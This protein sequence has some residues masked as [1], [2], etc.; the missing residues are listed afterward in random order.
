MPTNRPKDA[1]PCRRRPTPE[2]IGNRHASTATKIRTVAIS[3]APSIAPAIEPPS[4]CP[5]ARPASPASVVADVTEPVAYTDRMD[6]RVE[7][8]LREAVEAA[9]AK[10]GVKPAHYIRNALWTALQPRDAGSLYDVNSDGKRRWA[11]IKKDGEIC[12]M[13]YSAQKP[14]FGPGYISVPVTHEDSAPFDIEKHWRLKP[15]ET[16]IYEYATPARVVVTYP[17]VPKSSLEFA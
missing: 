16:L 12:G 9:A 6:I 8:R 2:T 5:E 15:H 14:E 10:H 11:R 4:I 3:P 1:N 7:P 13:Y 17:V